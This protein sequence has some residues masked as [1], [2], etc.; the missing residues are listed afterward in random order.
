MV[1]FHEEVYAQELHGDKTSLPSSFSTE[2][3]IVS[4]PAFATE[5]PHSS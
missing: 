3:T 4:S 2:K 5:L 1:E